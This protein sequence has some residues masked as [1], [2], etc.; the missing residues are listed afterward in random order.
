[1]A[2]E[3]PRPPAWNTLKVQPTHMDSAALKTPKPSKP[4]TRTKTRISAKA[5][6]RASTKS[7]STLTKKLFSPGQPSAPFGGRFCACRACSTS[8]N[9]LAAAPRMFSH[10]SRRYLTSR[11]CG[12]RLPATRASHIRLSLERLGYLHER[13]GSEQAKMSAVGG[14]NFGAIWAAGQN[15]Y[16]TRL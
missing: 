5:R 9:S 8:L 10:A 14:A 7:T 13:N 6:P 2:E 3:N 1:M 12:I 4:S 11:K 16:R 15:D